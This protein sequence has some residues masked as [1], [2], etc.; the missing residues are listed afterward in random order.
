M[1]DGPEDMDQKCWLSLNGTKV[2]DRSVELLRDSTRFAH[3]QLAVILP[4]S[5]SEEA[6]K[7]LK[8][9]RLSWRVYIG[10]T[11]IH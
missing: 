5:V 6:A 2:T 3:D 1:A 4:S 8:D 10:A 7:S 11:E 9:S